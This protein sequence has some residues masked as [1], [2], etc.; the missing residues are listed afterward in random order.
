[1]LQS[2]YNSTAAVWKWL[3]QSGASPHSHAPEILITSKVLFNFSLR[4][5][6]SSAILFKLDVL[7]YAIKVAQN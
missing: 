7:G 6:K 4:N 3:S 5:Q 2:I 1:M